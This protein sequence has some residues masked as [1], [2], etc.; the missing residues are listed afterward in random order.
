M[1]SG[2]ISLTLTAAPSYDYKNKIIAAISTFLSKSDME[3]I[4]VNALGIKQAAVM[5]SKRMGFVDKS[6]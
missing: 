2:E 3:L 6:N 4:N 1:I 5:I